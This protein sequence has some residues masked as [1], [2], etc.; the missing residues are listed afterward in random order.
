MGAHE[1]STRL[2]LSRQRVS[3]LTSQSNFPRPL[4]DL[5]QG[6]VWHAD[7]VETWI[8]H[9]RPTPSCPACPGEPR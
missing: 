8:K 9:H 2:H 6:K 1:I 4:A 3:Q 7:D 5:R